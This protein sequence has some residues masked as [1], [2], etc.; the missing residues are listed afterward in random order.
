MNYD[1]VIENTNSFAEFCEKAGIST[2]VG[3]QILI[4]RLK[5]LKGK[6]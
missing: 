3:I 2:E 5:E 6:R 1:H 4:E